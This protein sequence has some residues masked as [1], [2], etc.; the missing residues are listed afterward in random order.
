MDKPETTLKALKS[1]LLRKNKGKNKENYSSYIYKL[2]KQASVR[3][4]SLP[5]TAGHVSARILKAGGTLGDL[6]LSLGAMRTVNSINGDLFERIASEAAR[7]ALSNKRSTI[8]SRE[9]Q[10][11]VK[12]VLPGE[13]SKHALSEGT[14]AVAKDT[15]SQ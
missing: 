11:A 15:S 9:V 2:L 3:R 5:W 1:V 12:L 13:L 14:K 6:C 7:L 10:T 8:T 4:C